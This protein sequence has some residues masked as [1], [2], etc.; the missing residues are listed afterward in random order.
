MLHVEG[1][2]LLL[3]EGDGETVVAAMDVP[4]EQ[5]FVAGTI[6]AGPSTFLVTG[7]RIDAF[8]L[9][10]LILRWTR[11]LTFRPHP[12]VVG[13]SEVVLVGGDAR[14]TVLPRVVALDAQTGATLWTKSAP[15]L[16]VGTWLAGDAAYLGYHDRF[17]AVDLRTGIDRWSTALPN[18]TALFA[19]G[20]TLAVLA[21]DALI[22]LDAS[23]GHERARTKVGSAH[24]AAHRDGIVYLKVTTGPAVPA[25]NVGA[26]ESV[27]A[28]DM[29]SLQV[30]WRTAPYLTLGEPQESLALLG[31]DVLACTNEGVLRTLDARSG[32]LRATIGLG[33]C[34]ALLAR[35]HGGQRWVHTLSF[36]RGDEGPVRLRGG[37][38]S[39]RTMRV[40]G[41]VMTTA[42]P[43]PNVA[44]TPTPRAGALV[45]A[46]DATAVTDAA[47]RFDMKVQGSGAITVH[48]VA[49]VSDSSKGC[50]RY[51]SGFA[52]V[53][54]RGDE[55]E[56]EPVA[57]ILSREC[58][59]GD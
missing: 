53:T 1:D 40:T 37:A 36:S 4:D 33:R 14:S 51:E 48:A 11:E 7:G 23:N 58:V 5:R 8:A 39:S 27:L 44:R 26:L 2:R 3:T 52:P 56:H 45:S 28:V 32:A 30:M 55:G 54:A 12:R 49:P 57:L 50:G 38:P 41:V 19:H 10:S 21:D 15:G 47:G 43:S 20:G 24:G 16:G 9:P 59:C 18:L 6:V 42:A 34:S 25:L 31:E 13:N 35:E 22:A 46:L 29:A 17:V